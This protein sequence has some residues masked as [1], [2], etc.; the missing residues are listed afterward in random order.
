VKLERPLQSFALT[1]ALL[2]TAGLGLGIPV[3]ATFLHTGLV[4][5]LPTAL[6]ATGL[7]L[8]ASL[9]FVCGL[10][11]ESV[12]RGRKEFKRLAYLSIP[13]VGSN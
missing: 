3:V 4:P 9:A 12:A 11:L 5:R 6:L 7:V 10:V 13:I 1:G 8:A 2:L